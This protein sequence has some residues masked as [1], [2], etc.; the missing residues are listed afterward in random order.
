[1]PF[2]PF[3]LGPGLLIAMVFVPEICVVALL[4]G[5]VAPDIEPLA[6]VLMG[7][8]TPLHGF[9]HTYLGAS[10]LGVAVAGII[11][12]LRSAIAPLEKVFAS[13]GSYS[14]RA[15]LLSALAGTYSHVF[16]DSFLYPE[17][18]PFFPVAGNPFLGM[19]PTPLAYEICVVLGVIGL[20]VWFGRLSLSKDSET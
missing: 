5:S 19:L 3:H 13:S 16:L 1:M 18:F 12:P 11:W 10:L 7:L 8:D 2:T 20:V 17:M 14:F 15:V 6:I 9:L 4:I